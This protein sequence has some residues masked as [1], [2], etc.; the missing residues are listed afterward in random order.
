MTNTLQTTA[1]TALQQQN[2][3]DM[4]ALYS[5]FIGYLDA[6]PKTVETYRKALKQFFNFLQERGINFPQRADVLAYKEELQ[7]AGYKPTTIQNYITA[8]KVFFNWTSQEGVYP[9]I[10]EHVKGAKLDHE[11][12]KDYFSNEQISDM[13]HSIKT[14]DLQGLRDYALFKVMSSLGLRDIEAC[15]LNVE[16]LRMRGG[17]TVL[18]LQRKG[19][20][21]KTAYPI[22]PDAAEAIRDY[23]KERGAYTDGDPLFISLSNHANGGR[24]TTRSISRA[25]KNIIL[26]N[27]YDS[28]RLTS[29]S[30]RHSAATN[31]LKAG[32]PLPE[33]QRFMGHV[34]P[35]T[36]DIYNHAIQL[37]ENTCAKTLETL[38]K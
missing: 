20:E 4:N 10:A 36:T 31:A 29:H 7:G 13:Q 32:I 15:R 18:F 38:Y 11:F 19:H 1:T 6:A 17:N 8:V 25:I 3:A 23:L 30:L 28:S 37:E 2:G 12:K 9:N 16:D 34:S 26:A 35:A 21:E 24:L 22:G 33:V 14:D 5:S 27:G